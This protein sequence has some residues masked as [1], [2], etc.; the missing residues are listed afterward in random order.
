MI[1]K[2]EFRYF[3]VVFPFWLLAAQQ[4]AAQSFQVRAITAEDG[5]SH[6]YVSSLL[7]DSR[8]YVWIGTIYGLNRYDGYRCKSYTPNQLDA[9]ALHTAIITAIAEDQNGM[10]WL[11]TDNGL[12]VFNPYSEKFIP[13]IKLTPKAPTG[14]IRDLL[15]DGDNNIWC[16][17]LE[18]GT[19]KVCSIQNTAQLS[20]CSSLEKAA[21][22]T[23]EVGELKLPEAFGTTIRL[24][25]QTGKYACLLANNAGTFLNL[26]FQNKTLNPAPRPAGTLLK[27]VTQQTLL[28]QDH[29][30]GNSMHPDERCAVLPSANGQNYVCQFF[31]KRIFQLEPGIYPRSSAEIAQKTVIATLDQPQ[32]FAR[33]VDRSGKIWVGTIGYGVRVIEP[34]LSAIQYHFPNIS[35]CNPSRMPNGKIW[36]GLYAPDQCVDLQTGQISPPLWAGTLAKTEKVNAALFDEPNNKIYLVIQNQQQQ[37]KLSVFVP[38]EKNL[39]TVQKLELFTEDPVMLLKDSKGALWLAGTGGEVLRFD[40]QTQ[41]AKHWRLSYL[42]PKKVDQGEQM[43]RCIAEDKKGRIWIGSDV[44]LIRITHTP[45]GTDFKSFHNESKNGPIFRSPWIFSICPHADNPDLLWLGTMSG[46]LALFDSQNSKLRYL[47]QDNDLNLVIGM[48]PDKQNNLWLATNKGVLQYQPTT[49]V[50]VSYAHLKHIPKISLNTAA[51]FTDP[52]GK[53]IMGGAGLLAIT[54]EA[55]NPQPVKGSLVVTDI[56]INR[57][58]AKACVAGAKLKLNDQQELSLQLAHDDRFLLLRFS[59]P[60]APVPEAVFYRYRVNGLHKDWIFLGQKRTVELAGLAP[61]KYNL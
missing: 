37:L 8:G 53:V 46:G 34:I 6:G 40:P 3:L 31:E 23:V 17:N 52:S 26:D 20:S 42:F 11:G 4:P 22:P 27:G 18:G 32:S 21:L 36:A 60:A 14:F 56:E 30:F 19:T 12:A 1:G 58:P 7:Q 50:F 39:R 43:A 9:R 51:I 47:D 28:F 16:T 49:D 57:K 48:T 2:I 5:L 29:D 13:L 25:L 10:L 33:I 54:P 24:F 44:G 38:G 15:V 61:G 45:K 55:G 41:T 35:F 59:V